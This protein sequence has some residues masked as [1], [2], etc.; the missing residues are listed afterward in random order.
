MTIDETIAK[1]K[2]LGDS[3]GYT[4]EVKFDCPNCKVTTEP[5]SIVAVKAVVLEK[6]KARF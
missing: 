4:V 2:L 6:R 5:D 1:L 3:F